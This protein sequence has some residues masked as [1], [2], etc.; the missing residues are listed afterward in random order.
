M[1][2]KGLSWDAGDSLKAYLV[3]S[4]CGVNQGATQNFYA[5]DISVYRS[6]TQQ[7]D[8]V[9]KLVKG[10]NNNLNL[11]IKNQVFQIPNNKLT[12]G[13]WNHIVFTLSGTEAS[14]YI[15]DIKEISNQP[16]TYNFPV[17][18]TPFLGSNQVVSSR[19]DGVLDEIILY[20]TALTDAEIQDRVNTS[21]PAKPTNVEGKKFATY[22][23]STS[24][25]GFGIM[26]GKRFEEIVSTIYLDPN[27][28][29]SY[30]TALFAEVEGDIVGMAS[31]FTAE[32]YRQ[33]RKDALNQVAG[34]TMLRI[35]FI[36]A[37]ALAKDASENFLSPRNAIAVVPN[38]GTGCAGDSN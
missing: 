11:M 35:S 3:E 18:V 6:T 8:S 16:V 34:R 30:E 25:G 31:G 9:I 37:C 24:D 33:F 12:T 4:Y 38:C 28:D 7:E 26:F 14:L 15:N 2:S 36:C 17:A 20:N 23:N 21:A 1:L 5:D 22:M 19:F 29:L 10:Q 32:Q 27:H 13:S